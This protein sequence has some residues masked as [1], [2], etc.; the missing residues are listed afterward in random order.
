MKIFKIFNFYLCIYVLFYYGIEYE[1]LSEEFFESIFDLDRIYNSKIILTHLFTFYVLSL[2]FFLNDSP[3]KEPSL[4]SLWIKV[5][6]KKLID[7]LNNYRN[8]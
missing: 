7:E 1:F 8:E 2:Y 5:K 3:H 6:K 4:L